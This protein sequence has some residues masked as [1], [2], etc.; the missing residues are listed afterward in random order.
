[1]SQ[2]ASRQAD[3]KE[4]NAT[5]YHRV[6]RPHLTWGASVIDRVPV[7]GPETVLDAGCGTGR[8][9]AELLEKL[10]EARVIAFDRS[11][12]MLD[13]ARA[14]L[15]PTYGDRVSY[16]QGDLQNIDPEMIGEQVDGIF[17]TATFHWVLDHP[18]LFAGLFS[19]LRPG[20]WFEAQCG[21]GPNLAALLARAAVLMNE[22]P[23]RPFF[24]GWSGPWEFADAETTIARLDAAGFADADANV[25]EAPTVLPDEATYRDFLG[26]VVFGTH[27]ARLPNDELKASFVERLTE[28]GATDDPPYSLD[29]WRLNL[30]GR[31]A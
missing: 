20:G 13:Q 30:R 9:T 22:D 1:V 4:W 3:G 21:G 2:Q 11:L 15:E 14:F 19:V 6:A 27:L 16:R 26:N 29:Y 5:V 23:Y 25:I 12:N 18:R 28:L 7:R 10:P 24:E 8:L 31:K 17:S